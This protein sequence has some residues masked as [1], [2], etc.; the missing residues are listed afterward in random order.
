MRKKLVDT[1]RLC[2]RLRCP[3]RRGMHP[4]GSRRADDGPGGND[5]ARGTTP[6]GGN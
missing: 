3:D 4:A 6:T 1:G 2:G 5:A